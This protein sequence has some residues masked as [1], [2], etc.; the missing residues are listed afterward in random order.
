[1]LHTKQ[2][3]DT[4]E[5][6]RHVIAS[7]AP[8]MKRRASALR[9]V[10]LTAE[11]GTEQVPTWERARAPLSR[12]RIYITLALGLL[13]G[14]ILIILGTILVNWV[15][16]QITHWHGGDSGV[17]TLDAD[18]GHDSAGASHLLAFYEAGRLI[19]V[20]TYHDNQSS[21]EVAPVVGS[22]SDRHHVTALEIVPTEGR[23]DLVVTLDGSIQILLYNTGSSFSVT[24]AKP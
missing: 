1:M 3:T 19:E 21:H 17:M 15:G 12:H 9:G 5:L 23:R 10:P 22:S 16:E 7:L 20:E 14:I 13:M 24:L 11:Q 8:H 6:D 18:T 4:T 2:Q